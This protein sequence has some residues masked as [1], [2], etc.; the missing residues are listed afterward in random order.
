MS[1]LK[2]LDN[3]VATVDLSYIWEHLGGRGLL[4]PAVERASSTTVR[5]RRSFIEANGAAFSYSSTAFLP[6]IRL[7]SVTDSVLP[8]CDSTVGG[9]FGLLLLLDP[10]SC[11]PTTGIVQCDMPRAI[12]RASA[13]SLFVAY[14]PTEA[15]WFSLRQHSRTLVCLSR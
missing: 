14:S 5:S 7:S 2:Y 12:K 13:A 4:R 9:L 6:M 8:W 3:E 1:A 15:G 11:A 10:R